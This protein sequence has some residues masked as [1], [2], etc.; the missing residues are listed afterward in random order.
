M[1]SHLSTMNEKKPPYFILQIFAKMSII[2]F[3]G[4]LEEKVLFISIFRCLD[5][6]NRYLVKEGKSSIF[7]FLYDIFFI[8]D[9]VELKVLKY[10]LRKVLLKNREKRYMQFVL[11]IADCLTTR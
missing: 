10:K 6:I 5:R 1:M 2:E 7:L 8:K 4:L 3:H 9:L 11:D